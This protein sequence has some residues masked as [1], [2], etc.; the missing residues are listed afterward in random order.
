[1]FSSC[2]RENSHFG[3]LDSHPILEYGTCF[4]GRGGVRQI[5][6]SACLRRLPGLT[7][8]ADGVM[9]LLTPTPIP[10]PDKRS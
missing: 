5:E 2:M 9:V 4:R 3:V 1:M 10:H 8:S 7:A 6:F